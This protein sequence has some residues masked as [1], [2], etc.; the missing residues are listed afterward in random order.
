MTQSLEFQFILKRWIL[1]VKDWIDIRFGSKQPPSIKILGRYKTDQTSLLLL[2][3]NTPGAVSTWQFNWVN[4]TSGDFSTSKSILI[5]L[6]NLTDLE[7]HIRRA[8]RQKN[9]L[10]LTRETVHRGI[11]YSSHGIQIAFVS[12]SRSIK[13]IAIYQLNLLDRDSLTFPEDKKGEQIVLSLARR[14]QRFFALSQE[15]DFEPDFFQK[16]L[17]NPQWWRE[18]LTMACNAWLA[19]D[20]EPK[21]QKINIKEETAK[22]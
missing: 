3:R 1:I 15:P 11:N 8:E 2:E 13:L 17:I 16:Q 21:I 4:K 14:I 7:R 6:D 20:H 10:D 5:T 19:S 9:P 18:G 22:K 12:T